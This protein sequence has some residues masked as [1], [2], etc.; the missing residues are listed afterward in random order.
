MAKKNDALS[1]TPYF[2]DIEKVIVEHVDK[3][4]NELNVAVAWFTNENIFEH[5]ILALNRGVKVI[6]VVLY[7]QINVDS[8]VDFQKFI[9][10]GGDFYLSSANNAIMHNKYCII[11]GMYTLTGSYN[12]TYF[13]EY[14][15]Y[16]NIIV[17]TSTQ[18]AK[19]YSSDFLNLL[20]AMDKVS[21]YDEY[22]RSKIYRPDT[23]SAKRVITTDN[24]QKC[25]SEMDEPCQDPQIYSDR[26]KEEFIIWDPVYKM[27]QKDYLV[28]QIMYKQGELV[29]RFS[30]KTD[31]GCFIWSPKTLYVW[32]LKTVPGTKVYEA[33]KI[34]NIKVDDSIV[35][36]NTKTRRI[37][38]FTNVVEEQFT[39]DNHPTDNQGNLVDSNGK[40][41][42]VE[43][44]NVPEK[45]K[46]TCDIHFKI[47]TL[48][49]FIYSLYEGDDSC[50]TLTNYWHALNI[51]LSINQEDL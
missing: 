28:E 41:Y 44:I 37:Y 38:R 5:L 16:E 10:A 50:K 12:F 1:V 18:I 42:I 40:P 49:T 30:T 45:F 35:L 3:A 33:H 31:S 23:F 25:C 21:N 32:K 8:G 4:Q 39:I 29:I 51:N 9:D 36:K 34:S 27:W 13:A 19:S 26:F 24:Y 17:I 7:D 47:D 11:D 48:E 15:N 22:K 20:K 43:T 2:R 14:V 6:L 46:L